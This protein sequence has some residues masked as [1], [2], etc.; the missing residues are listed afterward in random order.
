VDEPHDSSAMGTLAPQKSQRTFP[1]RRSG[2][3]ILMSTLSQPWHGAI[4]G[5]LSRHSGYPDH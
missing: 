2:R 3:L 5:P 4:S 1:A